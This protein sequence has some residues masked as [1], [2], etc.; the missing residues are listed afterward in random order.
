MK[1]SAHH[2]WWVGMLISSIILSWQSFYESD[3][4][5]YLLL[6]FWRSQVPTVTKK[7]LYRVIDLK[8]WHCYFIF[9]VHFLSNDK[10]MLEFKL[11]QKDLHTIPLVCSSLW[12]ISFPTC[13]YLLTQGYYNLC[14]RLFLMRLPLRH[15]G[16]SRFREHSQELSF[17]DSQRFL[18]KNYTLKKKK[19]R[20]V[21]C[22]LFQSCF[23]VEPSILF[24]MK[25]TTWN[26]VLLFFFFS[27][28]LFTN[29]FLTMVYNEKRT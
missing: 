6:S 14:C 24:W 5:R 9:F 10:I 12:Y 13:F 21:D 1:S 11:Q 15:F 26:L 19:I 16:S 8:N 23:E 27:L 3:L 29:G 4:L 7:L 28:S 20:M 22:L 25:N 2:I 17:L 18:M